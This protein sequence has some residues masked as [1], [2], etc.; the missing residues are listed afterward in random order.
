MNL[1]ISPHPNEYSEDGSGSGG[2]WRVVNAQARWLP[3]YGIDIVD[4]EKDADV[5]C[6]H[7]G[8]LVQTNK[9]IVTV[10]HGLYWTGDF[11]W[12]REQW[13]WNIPVVEA[14]REAHKIIVPA[15]WVAQS[16]MQD[17]R[18]VPTVIPHG[19]NLE[20][21][22]PQPH[23]E[24]VLWGKPRVDVVSD[25][26]PVNALAARALG[27]RFLTTFG[28]ATENVEVI[29]THPYSEFKQIIARAMV[30]LATTRET[31]DIASREAMA[32]GV[33]VLGWDWG[34]TS[35]LVQ[36]LETGY[37]ARPGDYDDL[38][39]GLHYCVE[40]RAR[41]G[42]AARAYVEQHC[43]WEDIM[44]DY[45]RVI[46]D[47]YDN[48]RYD[49]EVSVVIPAYN[50]A[51]FLPECIASVRMQDFEDIE[52]IV[53]DN[54]S[55]DNTQAVLA[56]Y[57]GL[58]VIRHGTNL[59]LVASLN[60]GHAAARGRYIINL[61]ADNV[62][63]YGAIRKM[64]EAMETKPWVDVGT[65]L[66]SIYGQETVNGGDVDEQKHLAHANQI[67]STCIIRSRSIRHLGGY[68]PRQVKNEDAE[69]WCR[70][71]SAGLRCEYLVGDP[72]FAY[73]WHGKNKTI[74]EGGE[75]EPDSPDSW[76]FY[77]PW[78]TFKSITPFACLTK[79]AHHSHEVRSYENPHI[80]V[81]IPVG[82]GHE[83]FLVDA[84]DSVYAQ[85]FREFE[86][87]V[88]NDTGKP[89]DV[90][91]LGHP[92]V[93]V[94]DTGG[95]VGPAK[96]RNIAIGAAK[97]PLI[98]PLDAD[99]QMYPDTLMMYYQAWLQHPDSLVYADCYTEDEPGKR[100]YYHSGPWTWE[101]IT[102]EAIYQSAILFAR[103][104]WEAVG[105]YPTD[106]LDDMWEDWLF[107]VKLHIMGIGA[108]YCKGHPWGSYRKWPASASG[109][110]KNS[111]DNAGHGT[112]EFKDKY[113]KLLDWIA[114]KEE[115]MC[116]GCGS[117]AKTRIVVPFE[118]RA[119][120]LPGGEQMQVICT[121]PGI[122]A[123][124]SINS[125]I[126]RGKKYRYMTDTILTVDIGDEWIERHKH[127][128]RYTP[129]LETVQAE[130]PQA[131]PSPPKL[132]VPVVESQAPAVVKK[133]E[134]P[135]EPTVFEIG[136]SEAL[137]KKLD[138]AGF[139]TR[140]ALRRD[141]IKTAG[142]NIKAIKGIGNKSLELI[143][144][145]TAVFG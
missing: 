113:E 84:L 119:E 75:D 66:Y 135:P 49:V 52:I 90:A 79:P 60:T 78:H 81:I 37:L 112:Q 101:K 61:D 95:R 83:Y 17:M 73:R 106:Q 96:A 41:L 103:Q 108:T 31:G 46:Q 100:V 117:K 131:P 123:Y 80:A 142:K 13:Q 29:G 74:Q 47:A 97:A 125:R 10:N 18:K 48:D 9:P 36:H 82:P 63:A 65:G 55:T 15:R 124:V 128:E 56:E 137:A 114:G 27:V 71:M 107:G 121:Q 14:L 105:G 42:K 141:I 86:C 76:N 120:A 33:P 40:N 28:Q 92:W 116:K 57:E 50:Y 54:A 58:N 16:I 64:H 8:A 118:Y 77:Y 5:V 133:P 69:F 4:S 32:L 134:P 6:I 110:S 94:V 130:L 91:V 12:P 35:E 115:T 127:F 45:A 99:D 129:K 144:I 20:E 43:Q 98:V 140:D 88:A 72:V 138:A 104:W 145:K 25:P 19:V 111:I 39:E 85:T 126:T 62:L 87:V 21:F 67:P 109:V 1:F 53:I 122:T 34:A 24:Y 89:L 22:E 26:A 11:D 59:G 70:A 139:H 7:A 23:E 2:I 3:Q 44:F 38:L 136:L 93:K 30:W 132:P 68:R 51:R 143:E 102:R